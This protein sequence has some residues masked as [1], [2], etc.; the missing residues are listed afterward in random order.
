MQLGIVCITIA[1]CLNKLQTIFLCIAILL[2]VL[3]GALIEWRCGDIEVSLLY[4]VR[5]EAE[6]ERH[7]ERVD[8]R[9]ID[10]GIGHDDN[11]IVAQL[12]DICLL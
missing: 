2:V 1:V 9:A 6:E 12:V 3:V 10:I 8:M 7:D 4:H 5:H 11:L